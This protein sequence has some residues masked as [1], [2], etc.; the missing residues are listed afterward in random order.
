VTPEMVARLT[1]Q[2]WRASGERTE[3]RLR[4]ISDHYCA[5]YAIPPAQFDAAYSLAVGGVR[6][7][8]WEWR[9]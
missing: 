3:T 6:E 1:L 4:T 8:E 2:W 7:W 9:A 5:V